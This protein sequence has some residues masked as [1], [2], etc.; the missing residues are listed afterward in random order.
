MQT[1]RLF[2][3]FR[4]LFVFA[5]INVEG[6]GGSEAGPETITGAETKAA[7]QPGLGDSQYGHMCEGEG[8]WFWGRCLSRW[9]GLVILS[10]LESWIRL[11]SLTRHFEPVL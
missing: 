2:Q 10:T 3:T 5:A 9:R 8:L 4:K 6:V 11:S 1:A 7:A